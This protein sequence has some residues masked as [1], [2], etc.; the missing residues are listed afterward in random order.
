MT[1]NS[2]IDQYKHLHLTQRYGATSLRFAPDLLPHVFE[3]KPISAIDYGCG[4]S[5]LANFMR[6]CGIPKVYQYDPA[7]EIYS[8]KPSETFDLLINVD[9]LEHVPENELD[10]I[11]LDM[12][13]LSDFAIFV[14]DIRLAKTILPNG[15]NAHV[16][17][18]PVGWWREKLERYYTKVEDIPVSG[19]PRAAFKTWEG[20][21]ST[22]L[23]LPFSK[24][25]YRLKRK[26][27]KKYSLNTQISPQ[28]PRP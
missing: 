21:K 15:M 8:D 5:Q 26:F 18:K 6:Y 13:K 25:Y 20:R 17:V 9:V 27:F 14:I 4:Q 28:P 10:N 16:T 11:F 24:T 2:L 7:I 23:L 12:R 1:Q 3:R 22:K 19:P